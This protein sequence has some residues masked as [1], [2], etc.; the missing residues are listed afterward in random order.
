MLP[1]GPLAGADVAPILPSGV[2]YD[3]AVPTPEEVL[4]YPIGRWHL[5]HDQLL[6]YLD[7]LAAAS[8]RL[9]LVEQGLTHQ[10][11]RLVLLV[12]TSP[13]NL[14]GLDRILEERRRLLDPGLPMPTSEEVD[15]SPVV[16]YLGY[17]IHGNEASGSNA[18]AL[19][20]YHLA[21]AESDE[22]AGWL[23][24]SVVLIDP[25]LNPD[26]MGRFA[27]WVNMHRGERV[28]ADENHREHR[29]AW[30]NGRTNHY[31]FDLNRDWLL[32]QHPESRARVETLHR[33]LPD[34]VGDFH[35]MGSDST[36]FFQPGVP[37]RENPLK[38]ERNLEL[39]RAL[40]EYHARALGEAGELFYSGETFDDFYP[41]KGSTYPDLIGSVG[42]LFEQAS[43]RGHAQETENGRLTFERAISNHFRTSLSM[44]RGGSLSNGIS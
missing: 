20:A 13:S 11:R 37:E 41:G 31:W 21:A 14:A 12:A 3:A 36:Y 18:A 2:E 34:L 1:A 22:V 26:G 16:I 15:A 30:P 17:S 32:L 33:W 43:A 38:P 8:A 9:T 39:T 25:S 5:R 23:D 29:E 10:G 35:E 7:R 6:T 27:T 4:G 44:V 42:V 28:V 40:A 19:V 24:R